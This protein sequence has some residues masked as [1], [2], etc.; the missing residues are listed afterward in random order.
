MLEFMKECPV[1]MEPTWCVCAD[2]S[3]W[4]RYRLEASKKEDA[5]C[6]VIISKTHPNVR[7]CITKGTRNTKTVEGD[8]VIMKKDM[9]EFRDIWQIGGEDVRETGMGIAKLAFGD[10][11]ALLNNVLE[12]GKKVPFEEITDGNELFFDNKTL[13]SFNKNL[14][15]LTYGHYM[16]AGCNKLTSFTSNISSLTN[17]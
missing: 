6:F 14:I 1:F 13:S 8:Y 5:N 4:N 3:F 12:K 16:F 7:F 9:E 2:K 11:T 17:G 15:A 10:I